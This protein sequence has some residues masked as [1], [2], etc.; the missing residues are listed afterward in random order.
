MADAH[1]T[2]HQSKEAKNDVDEQGRQP[3]RTGKGKR[4]SPHRPRV[5]SKI[6]DL[7]FRSKPSHAVAHDPTEKRPHT[8]P[9]DGGVPEQQGLRKRAVTFDEMLGKQE[10]ICN[11]ERPYRRTWRQ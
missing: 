2:P 10:A 9:E 3:L 1:S 8:Q 5:L 6:A 11:E 7:I 4:S